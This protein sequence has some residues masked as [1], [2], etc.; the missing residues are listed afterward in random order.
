MQQ[1]GP[2]GYLS[3]D[4]AEAPEPEDLAVAELTLCVVD[5]VHVF[6]LLQL[7]VRDLLLLGAVARRLE[8]FEAAGGYGGDHLQRRGKI[9]RERRRLYLMTRTSNRAAARHFIK[10]DWRYVSRLQ[11][12]AAAGEPEN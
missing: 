5:L 9:P 8:E 3:L 2:L 10:P 11:D 1:P 6:Q 7:L 4:A 12:G